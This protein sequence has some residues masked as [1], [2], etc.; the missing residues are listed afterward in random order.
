MSQIVKTSAAARD[1]RLAVGQ[2]ILEVSVSRI[3]DTSHMTK[4]V[5]ISVIHIQ[6]LTFRFI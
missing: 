1:G 2:R 3:I 5:D 6:I 4:L